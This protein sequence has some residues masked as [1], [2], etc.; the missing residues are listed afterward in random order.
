MQEIYLGSS[1]SLGIPKAVQLHCTASGTRSLLL[2]VL[3]RRIVPRINR[4]CQERLLLVSPEL[5]HVRIP[6][7]GRVDELAILLLALADVDRTDDIAALI[8]L[9]RSARGLGQRY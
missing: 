5:A 8:E 3:R 2:E 9:Q 1:M 4:V 7:D 6:L